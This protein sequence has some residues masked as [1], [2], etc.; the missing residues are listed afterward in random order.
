MYNHCQLRFAGLSRELALEPSVQARRIHG[1]GGQDVLE[2]GLG[3]PE[4]PD[5][6]E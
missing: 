5:A 3:Q 6:A 2:V 1:G 4:I